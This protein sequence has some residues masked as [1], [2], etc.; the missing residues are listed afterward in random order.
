MSAPN[1][2]ASNCPG[3]RERGRGAVMVVALFLWPTIRSPAFPQERDFK[4]STGQRNDPQ[5]RARGRNGSPKR[6]P[7]IPLAKSR[8]AADNGPRCGRVPACPPKCLPACGAAL[9]LLPRWL[10]V[11]LCT[12]RI[13]HPAARLWPGV[14]SRPSSACWLVYRSC[15]IECVAHPDTY[16]PLGMFIRGSVDLDRALATFRRRVG[17]HPCTSQIA[18]S[19]RPRAAPLA[20]VAV[21]RR[22]SY[23]V[24][25]HVLRVVRSVEPVRPRAR[26]AAP[27]SR[28]RTLFSSLAIAERSDQGSVYQRVPYAPLH[29]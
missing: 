8:P 17:M 16:A 25:S 13:E 10:T 2:P 23:G 12:V 6:D 5:D 14:P 20:W 24:L 1:G 22:V 7:D 15:R 4:A 9:R 18:D 19:E 21:R 11:L 27:T 3:C 28:A 29:G 26:R